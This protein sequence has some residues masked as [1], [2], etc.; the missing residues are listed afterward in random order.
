MAV[1]RVGVE[2]AQLHHVPG[3]APM[4]MPRDTVLYG[5]RSQLI[6]ASDPP[7][8]ILLASSG[9]LTANGYTEPEVVGRPVTLCQGAGT[10]AATATV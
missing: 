9:W 8:R 4:P 1:T 10:C 3:P 2:A 5:S 7:F 6:V